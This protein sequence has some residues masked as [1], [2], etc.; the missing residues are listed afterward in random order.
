MK[1]KE[2]L[3]SLNDF[4]E[5]NPDCLEYEVISSSD[6]EGNSFNIVHYSPSLG[7]FEDREFISIE[8]LDEYNR[9]KSEVNSVCIN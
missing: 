6:D 9:D 1:L 7:V 3:K 5:N 8:E 4:V 2:Y